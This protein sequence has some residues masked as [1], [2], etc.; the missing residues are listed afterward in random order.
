MALT[1]CVALR[2][3]AA[4][5]HDVEGVEDVEPR[6]ARAREGLLHERQVGERPRDVVV[7]V[8][9][10]E[11]ADET[12]RRDR[13]VRARTRASGRRTAHAADHEA[14]RRAILVAA[15]TLS[16][17]CTGWLITVDGSE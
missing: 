12:P 4:H 13:H 10:L 16:V 6:V 2:W 17:L 5:L 8:G 3:R 9:S 14:H 7:A 15:R 1:C 11:R